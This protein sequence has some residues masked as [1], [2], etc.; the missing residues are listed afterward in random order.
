MSRIREDVNVR[1]KSI[2]SAWQLAV[3][4]WLTVAKRKVQVK[5]QEDDEA[6]AGKRK[7]KGG[8]GR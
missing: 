1:I 3:S 4:R 5:K 2:E 7:R 8:T 6:K